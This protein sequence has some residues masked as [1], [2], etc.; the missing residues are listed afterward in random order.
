MKVIFRVDAS[1]DIGVG[2]MMRCL[3][4]AKELDARGTE[5]L[6]VTKK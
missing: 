4:L 1:L 2:H 6:F 3:T 5:C